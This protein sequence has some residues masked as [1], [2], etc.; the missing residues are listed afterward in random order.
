MYALF[1]TLITVITIGKLMA[2]TDVFGKRANRK[3]DRR[4]WLYEPRC[5]YQYLPKWI[6]GRFRKDVY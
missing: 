3:A 1:A 2:T 6:S 5:G 4:Q